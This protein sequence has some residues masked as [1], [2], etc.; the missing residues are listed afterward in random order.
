MLKIKTNLIMLILIVSVF[1]GCA[2][3]YKVAQNNFKY[4]E[5]I[6]VDLLNVQSSDGQSAW[7]GYALVPPRKHTLVRLTFQLTNTGNT[8]QVV[9][10]TKIILLN[11][12]TKTKYPVAKIYQVAP[13]PI[14]A[15][16]DLKLKA[17]EQVK[18]VLMYVFP[19]KTVPDALQINEQ[20]Y[21]I[22]YKEG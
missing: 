20:A 13:V 3:H 1:S 18:R 15:R 19:Q 14:G 22:A 17:G 2:V 21:V 6:N 10:L 16:D 11:T 5:G 9:D 7:G 12:A 4:Q 8:D